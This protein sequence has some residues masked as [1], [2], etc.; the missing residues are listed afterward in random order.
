LVSFWEIAPRVGLANEYLLPTFSSTVK[1]MWQQITVGTLG[2]Q[3]WSSLKLVFVGVIISVVISILATFLCI[4]SKVF[5]SLFRALCT[6][7]NPLPGL[8]V[9]PLI[10]MWFGIG[11]GA[12]IVLI[13]H[14][15]VWP[16]VDELLAGYRSVPPIYRD[17][18]K[19]IGL[20]AFKE[21]FHMLIFAIM[22]NF[23]SGIRIGWGRAW[24][25]LIGAEMVFGMMGDY[26]GLGYYIYVQRA[27]ANIP[28]MMA[29][30]LVIV[31]L[32]ILIDQ[33]VFRLI[34]KLTIEKWGMANAK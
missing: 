31:I 17:F 4:Y 24:R 23:L 32:G 21:T 20:N 19:N 33:F 15:I 25:A 30:V 22:P 28:R 27:Y 2:H 10:M 13:I 12:M 5:E 29:G 11:T 16:L 18:S 14:G 7:F 6:V 9:L 8:A 3:L 26:G 1:T 34:E